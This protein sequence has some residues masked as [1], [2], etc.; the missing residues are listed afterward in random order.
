VRATGAV[1]ARSPLLWVLIAVVLLGVGEVVLRILSPGWM[2]CFRTRACP[3]PGGAWYVT[4]QGR[5]FSV[6]T[7]EPLLAFHPQLFWWPRPDVYGTFWETAGVRTNS[8][9][10]RQGPVDPSARRNV[11]VVGDSVVWGAKVQEGERFSDRA[12]SLLRRRPGFA[13]VQV[14]NAGV[15]GFSSFQVLQFLREV[16]IRRFRPRVVVICAGINDVWLTDLSDRAHYEANTKLGPRIRRALAKSN[17]FLFLNRYVVEA[18]VWLGTGR[19]LK[20]FSVF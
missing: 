4:Q 10:L 5:N 14:V 18:V 9:G 20:G 19:N 17:L 7:G 11:L 3:Q 2:F 8:L 6:E 16:G 1:G 13:D 12:A 15:P